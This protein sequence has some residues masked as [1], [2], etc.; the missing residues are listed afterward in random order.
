MSGAH[1]CNFWLSAMEAGD[2]DS[3]RQNISVRADGTGIII[4]GIS[5]CWCWYS[6]AGADQQGLWGRKQQSPKLCYL[7]TVGRSFHPT[8]SIFTSFPFPGLNFLSLGLNIQRTSA[9]SL[10][11]SPPL[12]L[13]PLEGPEMLFCEETSTP[14][15]TPTGSPLWMVIHPMAGSKSPGLGTHAQQSFLLQQDQK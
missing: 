9:G 14:S 6:L 15:L 13:S 5:C 12:F 7:Q 8:Q 1:E 11:L 3:G 4:Y 2:M 10:F